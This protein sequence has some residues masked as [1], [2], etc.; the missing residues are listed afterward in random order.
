MEHSTDPTPDAHDIPTLGCA[1]VHDRRFRGGAVLHE[2]VDRIGSHRRGARGRVG[3]LAAARGHVARAA[4]G[5]Q[6][7][8]DALTKNLEDLR[9]VLQHRADLD[10][11][12]VADEREAAVARVRVEHARVPAEQWWTKVFRRETW[13]G[14]P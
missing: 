12:A 8:H 1:G 2:R 7:L 11:V 4:L 3:R 13:T 5:L 6:E 10:A 9:S 14:R